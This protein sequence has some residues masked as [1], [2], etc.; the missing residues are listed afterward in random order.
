MNQR[1]RRRLAPLA[2]A[3][4]LLIAAGTAAAAESP[5][6]P[7][8]TSS[9]QEVVILGKAPTEARER[10]LEHFLQHVPQLNNGE[11]L[12]RWTDPVCPIV[13]GM[14]RE[15]GEYVIRRLFQVARAAGAP[16][17]DTGNCQ[18]NVFI[19]ATAAPGAL[20]KA[21]GDRSPGIYARATASEVRA[22]E[23]T[24]RPV[25][26]WYKARLDA[27]TT[28][29]DSPFEGL[30]GLPRST[31]VIHHAD[32]TRLHSNSPFALT[33]AI[34]VVDSGQA[35]SVKVGALADYIAVASLTQLQQDADGAGA[36]SILS[37]FATPAGSAPPDGLT[38]WDTAY[39]YA[40]YHS[41][42]DDF[43]QSSTIALHMNKAL[44]FSGG[45]R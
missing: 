42:M 20:V 36:P 18:V 39:L 3:G 7:A 24:S 4:A 27:L 17:I 32:D 22:F 31:R 25:R 41:R 28:D 43:H 23:E 14:T 16:V 6:A 9:V 35:A 15:Q 19:I 29:A 45:S 30:E 38:D 34:V 40:L 5:P 1:P 13:V 10:Q 21:L 33:S 44:G 26:A 37:L 11:A 8:P 12:A 2:A